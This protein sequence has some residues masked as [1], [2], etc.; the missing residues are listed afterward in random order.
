MVLASDGTNLYGLSGSEL[1]TLDPE[2][3]AVIG[4]SLA[5]SGID[6]PTWTGAAVGDL[7]AVPEPTTLLSTVGLVSGG[8]LLRR[9]TQRLC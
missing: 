5:I 9:R 6:N 7:A 2:N 1:Y 8:L 3:G 4:D